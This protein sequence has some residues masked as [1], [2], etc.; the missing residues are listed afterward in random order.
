M[1]DANLLG[2]WVRRFLLEHLIADRG[3]SINTQKSYRD[4]LI[5]LLPFMAARAGKPADRLTVTDLSVETDT[6][7][8][9]GTGVRSPLCDQYAQP[10]TRGH[11]RIGK[12]HWSTLPGVR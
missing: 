4:M 2:P 8:S 6:F 10:A 1:S 9:A 5:L 3:L 11:P 12:V 7:V